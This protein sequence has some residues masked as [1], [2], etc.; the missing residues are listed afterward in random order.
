MQTHEVPTQTAAASTY[1]ATADSGTAATHA[2]TRREF[3]AGAA[4]ALALITLAASGAQA[5]ADEDE[6]GGESAQAD[7]AGEQ[8]GTGSLMSE[9]DSDTSGA[10]TG[11]TLN[12]YLTNPVGIEPFN[13]EEN[14][15]IQVIHNLFEPLTRYNYEHKQ[16]EP[17]A[18][19][20]YE[21]NDDATQF[22]FHLRQGATFHNGQPVTSHDFKYAWERLCNPNVKPAPSTLAYKVTQVKGA[23]EMVAGEATELDVEC[24][25]DYTLVV[26][27]K[28]PFADFDS[29]VADMATAPVPA[30]CTDT[31]EDFQAFRVAPVGNGPFQMEGEWVDSQYI[32]IKRYD[33]YWGDKALLDGVN[34]RI[35]RDDQTAWTEFQAGTLD[36]TIVPSGQFT[37][38]T[39]TYGTADS[40]GY[41]ANPGH[42]TLTGDE[43]SLFYLI[44]N[45]NN[46]LMANRDLRIAVSCAI[47]RQAICDSVFQGTRTPAANVLMPGFAGYEETT[48]DFCPAE[49]DKD[50]AAQYFDA[51]GYPAGDDGKRG[52]S[53]T[54]STNSG[55]ANEMCMTMIQADLAAC[56]V[57]VVIDVQEMASYLDACQTDEF[58]MGRMGWIVTI[59]NPY[60]VLN[61]LFYTGVGNNYAHYSNPEFDELMDQA[62]Q[63]VDT[64]ERSAAYQQA[65]AIVAQDFPVVPLFFYRHAYV[66]SSR[67]HNLFLGAGGFTR[68][69]KCWLEG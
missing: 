4:A 2:M 29:V 33:G 31:E 63:I 50:L 57:D 17:L 8:Q 51:A 35:F 18:C 52:L 41:V 47:N 1:P 13:A 3:V 55:S 64:D 40:D 19:E 42:Q 34:F 39:Q 38:S 6:Q 36:F 5:L 45:N 14:Q 7:S 68:L 30:G 67:V 9:V 66:T 69:T 28:A 58:Q 10:T 46:E 24:P 27:L 44:M 43:T 65:N 49:G 20:S 59:P 15:G 16:I 12:W 11:G 23:D 53:L 26:N 25:D 62:V 56:G 54:L 37:F 21:S 61:D 48:W 32:Q 22:T 60:Y